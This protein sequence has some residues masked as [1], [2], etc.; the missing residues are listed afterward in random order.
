MHGWRDLT[1]CT[2]HHL[3][4]CPLA[5]T[6]LRSL[7][8]GEAVSFPVDMKP[9]SSE[10]LAVEKVIEKVHVPSAVALP[11]LSFLLLWFLLLSK[12]RTC[13]G[14]Q[15]DRQQRRPRWHP[16]ANARAEARAH[17]LVI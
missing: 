7:F 14:H 8:A 1:D 9:Y 6:V 12:Q 4:N 5:H 15:D 2:A 17:L 11:P 16:E 13:T 10:T 3:A